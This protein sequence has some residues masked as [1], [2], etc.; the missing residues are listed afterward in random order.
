MFPV[1]LFVLTTLEKCGLCYI[2]DRSTNTNTQTQETV[3]YI[4]LID[5][6]SDI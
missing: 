2:S 1:S 5:K 6:W 4:P 3:Q